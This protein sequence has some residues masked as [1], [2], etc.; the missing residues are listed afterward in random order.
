M[1]AKEISVF[2]CPRCDEIHPSEAD[3]WGCCG[4]AETTAFQC[5]NCGEIHEDRE[6]AEECCQQKNGEGDLTEDE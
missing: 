1:D 3:A 4:G 6:S 5:G 2:R